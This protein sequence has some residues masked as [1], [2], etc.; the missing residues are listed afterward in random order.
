MNSVSPFTTPDVASP[1]HPA[2]SGQVSIHRLSSSE[3]PLLSSFLDE[4]YGERAEFKHPHR[5]RW[6]F[7]D[8]PFRENSESDLWP[9]WVARDGDRIV[10]QTAAQIEPLHGVPGCPR[11]AWSVDTIVLP[12]YR[13]CGIGRRLQQ[14]SQ[15]AH[16]AFASMSMS[17]ANRRI[18]Q[19][20]GGQQLGELLEWSLGDPAAQQTPISR[21][22]RTCRHAF[23][24]MRLNQA[25]R[26]STTHRSSL[27]CVP[28][29]RLDESIDAIWTDRK[30][31]YDW[32]INRDSQF[33]NWKY[34]DQPHVTHR[35]WRLERDRGHI[36]WIVIRLA[37]PGEPKRGLVADLVVPSH[38]PSLRVAVLVELVELCRQAG[39]TC[40]RV[41]SS[42]ATEAA[43]LKSTGFRL[44]RRYQPIWHLAG[45][46]PHPP[47]HPLFSLGDHDLG[48]YPLHRR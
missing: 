46:D 7:G 39:L 9:V 32:G 12:D 14:A 45:Q 47:R 36:G 27:R 5:W 43:A 25:T 41:G 42:S 3:W 11:L 6:Q 17:A 35:A 34:M 8:N 18:K 20:L 40:I 44:R 19:R 29:E 48:Q 37:G 16:Q 26:E 24:R 4:A 28:L 33:L 23:D 31:D 21:L 10:G 2:P 38:D 1:H 13:R 15:E 30:S 22:R